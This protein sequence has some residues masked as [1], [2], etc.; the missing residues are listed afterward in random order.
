MLAVG[1]FSIEEGKREKGSNP[2]YKM[3]KEGKRKKYIKRSKAILV[4]LFIFNEVYDSYI[5]NKLIL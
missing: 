3:K 2:S 1:K 4:Y 5:S